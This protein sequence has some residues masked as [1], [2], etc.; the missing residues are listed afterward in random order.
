MALKKSTKKQALQAETKT[1]PTHVCH[2]CGKDQGNDD[3]YC[4]GCKV[5]VCPDCD[6]YPASGNHKP[7]AHRTRNNQ[8]NYLDQ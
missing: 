7:E 3:G 1:D 2:F 4:Y 8:V 5:N 6:K